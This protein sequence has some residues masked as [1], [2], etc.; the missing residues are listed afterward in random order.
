MPA[1]DPG[2][3]LG[4]G[5]IFESNLLPLCESIAEFAEYTFDESDW[6]AIETALPTTDVERSDWYEYPLVG[7]VPLTL[8]VAA[9]PG[10]C[11]VF[12]RIAGNPDSRLRAQI[13]T[14]MTIFA[15]WE[16]TGRG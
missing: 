4:S 6:L 10:S 8:F 13:E 7:P 14:A 11:V 1:D 2:R 12:V 3:V 9:D 5:W 16:T 15:R